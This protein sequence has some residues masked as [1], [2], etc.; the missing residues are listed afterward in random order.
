MA[1]RS[2][3]LSLFQTRMVMLWE[4]LYAGLVPI[5]MVFA[6]FVGLA[7]FGVFDA[8]PGWLHVAAFANFVGLVVW[9]IIVVEPHL[10]MPRGDEARQRLERDSKLPQ[11]SLSDLA[12]TPFMSDK[13]SPLWQAHQNRLQRRLGR[14]RIE[15]PRAL[16]DRTDPYALRIPALMLVLVGL[17]IAGPAARDRLSN[18]V[19]PSFGDRS[20]VTA[21]VWIEPPAYTNQPPR[22]LVRGELLPEGTHPLVTVPSGSTLRVRASRS[23]GDAPAIEVSTASPVST[24]NGETPPTATPGTYAADLTTSGPVTVRIGR[25]RMTVP[26]EVLP[27]RSPEVSIIGEPSVEGGVRTRLTISIEDDYGIT[28]GEVVMRLAANLQR[29][30]DAPPI[31]GPLGPAR[32]DAPAL[33]GEPGLREVSL[34]LTEHPWAG[35]PVSMQITVTDGAGQSATSFA[36]T[37]VLPER[38]FYNP[39][40]RAVVE[41]RRNLALAPQ[42]W[43]RS[44][45]LFDALTVAPEIFAADAKEYLLL[46]T[47]YHDLEEGRGNNVPELVESLWPL[48]IALEDEGLTLARQRLEA[49]QEALRQ[50]LADGEPPEVIDQLV[51]DLR[52]AMDDYVAA[53]AASGDA[54]AQE[55]S[56]NESLETR[57]L[58]DILDEIA[59]LRRQGDSAAARARLAELEQMLQNLRISQG[60]SGSSSSSGQSAQG[61]R[62]G[63][64]GE[65]EGGSLG[66][67]GNLIDQQRRLADETFAA[68]RGDRSQGGLSDNQR[69][70]AD[71]ARQLG[72]QARGEGS[73]G[74]EALENAAQMMEGAARA[75]ER[76]DLTS[77]GQAQ[78]RAMGYLREGAAALAEEALA[79]EQNNQQGN[80]TAA[81]NGSPAGQA[82][83]R[84][85]LGRVYQSQGDTGI[86]IPDLSDPARVRELTRALRERLRDPNLPEEDRQYLERLLRRF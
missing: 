65:G 76:G 18:A 68:R 79:A 36:R 50:A 84:D 74:A 16:I 14:L 15:K 29:A 38:T 47:A 51:E 49:A 81:D 69:D 48:A 53:L 17:V 72:S 23:T 31:P 56:G 4:R 54:T 20:P 42:S 25:E 26:V 75:L 5:L 1:R 86:E 37:I 80:G 64:P 82:A 22:F 61:E 52:Q 44:L 59:A 7:L 85:P 11:G 43:Q 46:R 58:N 9:A 27:D 39:L 77:A 40:S 10:M 28:E 41:E 12:D 35:L 2:L 33:R 60:G 63:E 3:P 8:L 57:D 45:R 24:E 30:P 55:N 34:D 73:A 71:A 83:D 6:V 66:E 62:S 13:A 78:E 21:D 70:L 32:V 19:T 67:A